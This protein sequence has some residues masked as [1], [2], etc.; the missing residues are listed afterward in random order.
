MCW[1]TGQKE[2]EICFCE[3]CLSHKKYNSQIVATN[4]IWLKRVVRPMLELRTQT[5]FLIF[6]IYVTT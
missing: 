4:N 1:A 6:H 3:Q 2:K 5:I